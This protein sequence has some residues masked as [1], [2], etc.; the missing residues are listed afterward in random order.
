VPSLR[1]PKTSSMRAAGLP[2]LL[3]AEA[4]Q[5]SVADSA[6]MPVAAER[7][8]VRIARMIEGRSFESLDDL[9]AEVERAGQRG[10]FDT[11]AEA[12]AGRERTALERA[13]EVAYDAM[14]AEGRLQSKRARQALALSPDC[15]DAWG[16]L[17]GAASTPEAARER[18][19]LAVAAGVRAIGPERFKELTGEFW[20]HL[21]TRPYMR[22]RL[23]LAQT[24]RSLGRDVEA[25]AQLRSQATAR[26]AR[27][28][29]SKRPN[30]R[31][32]RKS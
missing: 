20:G 14:E 13:Q 9:N 23:G 8:S 21:D 29:T 12:V 19:E 17:A 24:L 27:S 25:L 22:A 16:V 7:S 18:Y 11:P 10:L 15:A 5:T 3:E 1:R 26:R 28:R 4:G 6:A 31:S 2:F 30:R 32:W